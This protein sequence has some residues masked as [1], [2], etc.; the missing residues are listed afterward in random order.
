LWSNRHIRV[1]LFAVGFLALA[2]TLVIPIVNRL[3]PARYETDAF[4]RFEASDVFVLAPIVSY[5][6]EHPVGLRPRVV[7]FG[8]SI[9]WGYRQSASATVPAEFQRLVPQVKVF[10]FG[11]NGFETGSIY[12]TTKAIIGSVDVICMFHNG[13][14]TLPLLANAVTVSS[15]DASRFGLPL[16]DPIE[17]SMEEFLGVWKLYRYSYRLQASLLGSSAR[18]FVFRRLKDI[19]LR[20]ASNGRGMEVATPHETGASLSENSSG[21]WIEIGQSPVL[22]SVDRV[23]ELKEKHSLLWDYAQLI[24][25]RQKQGLIVEI[26]GYES[27]LE[28]TD[29]SDLNAYFSPNVTFMKLHVHRDLLQEDALHFS[30]RGARAVAHAIFEAFRADKS[31]ARDM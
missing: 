15:E 17:Q 18:R 27:P 23:H 10:N 25:D 30:H 21:V 2:D 9:V 14:N 31:L 13:S 16:R 4:L 22:P 8:N 24:K 28:S 5:L 19:T 29:R 1:L 26:H 12:L 11:V 3:E 6:Q 20:I 7:F